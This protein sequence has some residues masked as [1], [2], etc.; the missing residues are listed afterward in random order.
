MDIRYDD[1]AVREV[2]CRLA[3]VD[4]ATRNLRALRH[5]M[6]LEPLPV[7]KMYEIIISQGYRC[8]YCPELII[9]NFSLDHIKPIARGGKHTL[10][11]IQFTCKFCNCS[12]GSG[13]RPTRMRPGWDLHKDEDLFDVME[14]AER[15]SLE[16]LGQW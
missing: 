5:G 16:P 2:L 13:D 3:M 15:N 10:E 1:D 9:R 4:L 11:N 14:R 12:K 6:I 8:I 7:A